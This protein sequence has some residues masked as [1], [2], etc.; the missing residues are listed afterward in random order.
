MVERK[1]AERE[2]QVEIKEVCH[3]STGQEKSPHSSIPGDLYIDER[4]DRGL[5]TGQPLASAH[6]PFVSK[7]PSILDSAYVRGNAIF[8]KP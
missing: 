2:E 8:S 7:A 1:L 3:E 5:R 6:A 4:T